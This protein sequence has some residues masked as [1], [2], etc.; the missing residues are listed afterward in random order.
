MQAQLKTILVR[1]VD[2]PA[3]HRFRIRGESLVAR[4][5][6]ETWNEG[7]MGE[8]AVLRL[9]RGGKSEYK[10]ATMVA[11]WAFGSTEGVRAFARVDLFGEDI[12]PYDHF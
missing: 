12:N 1:G 9:L 5:D 7:V 11:S 2:F 3:E 4:F 8:W 10:G 6:S